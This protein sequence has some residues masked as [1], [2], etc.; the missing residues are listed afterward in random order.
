MQTIGIIGGMSWY[1]T[2]N[3]YRI[4]NAK[5]Q[6]ALGG[7]HSAKIMI[8]SLDFDEVRAMQV[9]EDWDAAGELLAEAGRCLQ[10][11]GADTVLIGTNLMHK[12][13]PAVEAAMG[14]PLLHIADAV[15]AA[16]TRQGFERLAILGTKWV[17][18]EDFYAERLAR[19]GITAIAPAPDRHEVI[20]GII[21]D[22]LTQGI[23]TD[24]SRA[25]FVAEIQALKDAG[26]QAVVLACTEIELLISQADSPL[27]VI[28]SMATHAEA[29]AEACL[30][31]ISV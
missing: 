23:V 22:E 20:D 27:P 15:G 11:A 28:D 19:H 29:A 8:D 21:F 14:V 25:V 5:V 1:S 13:A 3:Y 18:A 7:H 12:V 16:A 9:A 30:A 17:M 24:A 26:A 31:P 4:I 10:R 6:E 2:I